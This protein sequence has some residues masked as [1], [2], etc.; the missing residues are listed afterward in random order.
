MPQRCMPCGRPAL[1]PHPPAASAKQGKWGNLS[2]SG[3]RGLDCETGSGFVPGQIDRCE[4]RNPMSIQNPALRNPGLTTSGAGSRFLNALA[5]GNASW[6]TWMG[7]EKLFKCGRF[8]VLRAQ[9]PDLEGQAQP[10][11]RQSSL[12][13]P[14]SESED[15][16]ECHRAELVLS[17]G[18]RHR[19]AA[20][21]RPF[22]LILF[23]LACST[24]M[25]AGPVR[26]HNW[27]VQ[28]RWGL[29]GLY[30]VTYRP[31]AGQGDSLSEGTVSYAQVSFGPLGKVST[32]L[33]GA[34]MAARGRGMMAV[35]FAAGVL[36]YVSW[37][38]RRDR[39][40]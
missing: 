1:R 25:G 29:V 34:A 21:T 39:K 23:C 32:K 5:G 24:A 13:R 11:T 38:C 16:P 28:T 9:S 7:M 2:L 22:W 8:P 6:Y 19:R 15:R 35:L 12:P 4:L 20:F 26:E 40:T 33:D 31:A 17:H 10:A 37:T 18:K 27:T 3:R 30:E 14:A 36:V